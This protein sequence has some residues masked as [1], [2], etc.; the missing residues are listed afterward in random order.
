MYKVEMYLRV[1]RACFV[2]G[3]SAREAARV[4]GLH[5]D[6]VRKM[7]KYSVP[8]GYQ[9]DRPPSR[10]KLDP[11]KGV[12]DQI[13]EEDQGVPKKQRHTAK[14]IYERLRDEHGFPGKYTIVKDYVRE[15]RRRTREMFVP[16]SHSP[17]HAQCDFGEAWVVIER[18]RRPT[19]WP[20]SSDGCLCEGL[21]CRDHRGLHR[22]SS[23][24]VPEHVCTTTPPWR[25][26]DIGRWPPA[27]DQGVHR[28]SHYLELDKGKVEG[29]MFVIAY[30]RCPQ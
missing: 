17:G 26:Q 12:I 11:Y 16:L 21:P 8:P 22:L 14:R 3:M 9:R 28:A 18:S 30:L 10:P 13:L 25:W 23:L 29:P 20:W 5:R 2:E 27:A 1:R 19:T 4:Y 24:C 6:T 15:R 7:L